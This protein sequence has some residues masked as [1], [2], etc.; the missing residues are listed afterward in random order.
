MNKKFISWE[1]AVTWLVE[2]PEHQELVRQC[3]FDRPVIEAVRRY[4]ASDEWS[5]LTRFLPSPGKALDIGA[6]NGIVSF[7]LAKQGWTVSALEPDPGQF[8]G[9]AAIRKFAD[10]ENLPITVAEE[11][12]ESMPWEDNEF[13]LVMARQVIHHANDLTQMYQ[14]MAR[15][16]KPGGTLIAFRDHVIDSDEG[17]QEFKDNHPLHNLYG[18]ENAFRLE[19]YV[20]AIKN[21][22]LSIANTFHQF[23]TVINY[24]P[25]TKADIAREISNGFKIQPFK[26]AGYHLI[27]LPVIFPLMMKIATMMYRKQ[28]RLVSFICNKP[29]M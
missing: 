13:D 28:G 16:L 4:A 10:S 9:A 24:A 8:V 11:F 6:G 1:D 29:T 18:G 14:E 15:I 20:G 7:A 25:K 12:G 5:A 2:Q 21:A 3:Y 17:L 23:D 19:E 27:K 22:G 26:M